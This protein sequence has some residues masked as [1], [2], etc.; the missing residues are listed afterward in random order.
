MGHQ[1]H[2][3]HLSSRTCVYSVKRS[4]AATIVSTQ[5]CRIS[6]LS[7][8]YRSHP[9]HIYLI[10]HVSI[11]TTIIVTYCDFIRFYSF[12]LKISLRSPHPFEKRTPSFV[13]RIKKAVIKNEYFLLFS[14]SKSC[15]V[16]I[17]K[18]LPA[19]N[20]MLIDLR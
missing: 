1:P 8:R 14:R 15:V 3:I 2:K 19:S 12:A 5:A 7:T 4:P 11:F 13:G 20:K 10:F 18:E 17:K 6:L 16:S 9:S